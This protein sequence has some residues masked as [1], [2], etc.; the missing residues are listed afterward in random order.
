VPTQNK[1]LGKFEDFSELLVVAPANS[2]VHKEAICLCRLDHAQIAQV[3]INSS[4]GRFSKLD[5]TI[6][7]RTLN[8]AT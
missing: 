3:T 5:L 2:K 8:E 7:F 6:A 4:I 1:A